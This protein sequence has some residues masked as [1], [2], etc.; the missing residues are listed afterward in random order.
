MEIH[1]IPDADPESPDEGGL[2]GRIHD[3]RERASNFAGRTRE[4]V[5]ETMHRASDAFERRDALLTNVR[6][7]P[8]TSVAL[9]FSVG[10][11]A[12]ALP[13]RRKRNWVVDRFRRQ[14]RTIIVS[15]ATAIAV[16]E[17]RE[18]ITHESGLSGL[19]DSLSDNRSS[20]QRRA[21]STA[22]EHGEDRV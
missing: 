15:G 22:G 20:G 5:E 1:N 4:G 13:G 3:V 9:A 6:E 16:S 14:L 7:H 18:I 19:V 17:L 8:L 11:V 12:A 21:S 2:R 10:F